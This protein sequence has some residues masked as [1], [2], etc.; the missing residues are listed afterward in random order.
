[1]SMFFKLKDHNAPRFVPAIWIPHDVSRKIMPE[2]HRD[3]GFGRNVGPCRC[4]V[5][6]WEDSETKR[7]LGTYL[8]A[9]AIGWEQVK[10]TYRSVHFRAGDKVGVTSIV[11]FA[12]SR[13]LITCEMA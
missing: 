8:F 3:F 13:E 6:C 2:R 12:L 4:G 1:M 9:C 5:G 7:I 11:I 10:R